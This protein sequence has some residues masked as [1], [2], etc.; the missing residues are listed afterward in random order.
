ML[1]MNVSCVTPREQ[2]ARKL[3]LGF[4]GTLPC[5]PLT[6]AGFALYPFAV[7]SHSCTYGYSIILLV[8][9]VSH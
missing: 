6:F 5:V 9:P 8:L 2:D 4:L 3:E 7:I 1:E